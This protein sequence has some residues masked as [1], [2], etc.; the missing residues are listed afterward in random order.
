MSYRRFLPVLFSL[1]AMLPFDALQCSQWEYRKANRTRI[2]FAANP[3][4]YK[5]SHIN[6]EPAHTIVFQTVKIICNVVRIFK[7]RERNFVTSCNTA[8]HGERHRLK[9]LLVDRPIY[10]YV[11]EE[12]EHTRTNEV[13]WTLYEL[14]LL[15]RIT[16]EE[17]ATG[18]WL[19]K[20]EL[21]HIELLS[22]K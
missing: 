5:R 19:Q 3:S 13:P 18:M 2:D 22:N 9:T 17:Q 14:D 11:Q 10:Y 15:R 8:H 20:L 7:N 12:K 4:I 16:T 21:Q 6:E 1:S